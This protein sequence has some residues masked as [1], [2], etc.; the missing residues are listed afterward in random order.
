[1]KKIRYVISGEQQQG[2]KGKPEKR[3]VEISYVWRT[4]SRDTT[5]SKR[6]KRLGR[7]TSREV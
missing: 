5:G 3:G 7:T 4:T 2:R 6:G 1:M